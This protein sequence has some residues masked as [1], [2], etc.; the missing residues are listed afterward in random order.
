MGF[1]K[2]LAVEL[3]AF[4]LMRDGSYLHIIERSLRVMKEMSLGTFTVLLLAKALEEC[5]K[6][7]RKDFYDTLREGDSLYC[8]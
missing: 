8:S 7:E 5:L 1:L 6:D 4:V 2:Q 3:K